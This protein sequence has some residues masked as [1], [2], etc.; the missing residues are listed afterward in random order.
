LYPGENGEDDLIN[1]ILATTFFKV[2]YNSTSL[3]KSHV[4]QHATASSLEAY[5]LAVDFGVEAVVEVQAP[6]SWI[7]IPI[8]VNEE[9]TRPVSKLSDALPHAEFMKSRSLQVAKANVEV[10]PWFYSAWH[11]IFKHAF[12]TSADIRPGVRIRL[13]L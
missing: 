1:I 3:L 10:K 2:T 4:A 7:D 9:E 11:L 5:D 12:E 8:D 6:E 13:F